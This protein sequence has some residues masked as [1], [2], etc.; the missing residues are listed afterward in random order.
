M[1]ELIDLMELEVI[2]A[3]EL[4]VASS[5]GVG[6]FQQ[7]VAKVAIAGLNHSCILSLKVARLVLCPDKSRVLGNSS[8]G[9]KAA[10]VA[11]LSDDTG[12]VHRTDTWDRGQGVGDDFELLF[13]SFLQHLDLTLQSPHRGD[14]YRHGLIDGVIDSLRKSVGASGSGLYSLSCGF[15]VSEATAPR[16]R[17]KS[18]QGFKVTVCQIVYRFKGFHK[19]QSGRT[20]VGN[21]LILCYAGAFEE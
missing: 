12:R 13:N 3:P 9:F 5:H 2:V 8:L 16:R 21:F 10:D 4:G 11:N 14:G 7:V 15:R 19:C 17:Y 6:G 1:L 20:G 18:S